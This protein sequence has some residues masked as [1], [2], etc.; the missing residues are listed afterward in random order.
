MRLLEIASAEEQIALWRLVSDNV[1]AALQ[2]QQDQ[3]QRAAVDTATRANGTAAKLAQKTPDK[4]KTKS[5][6]GRGSKSKA[7]K[8][9]L[10]SYGRVPKLPRVPTPS[11]PPKPDAKPATSTDKP[12]PQTPAP[13]ISAQGPATV[14]MSA[15]PAA[16][17]N[18]QAPGR[19]QPVTAAQ[20]PAVNYAA[21][22]PMPKLP[23]QPMPTKIAPVGSALGAPNLPPRQTADTSP[24]SVRPT[25]YRGV[26]TE[27]S[28]SLRRGRPDQRQ[29]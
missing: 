3:E 20:T 14:R 6:K 15:K 16:T 17:G 8:N 18:D 5:G 25:P 21:T 26:S 11:T 10:R 9:V 22:G 12:G 27:K 13:G 4:P 7:M 24:N 2:L 19:G 1:W 23:P 29:A 28:G